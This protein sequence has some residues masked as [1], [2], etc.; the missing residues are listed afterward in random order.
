MC[1]RSSHCVLRSSG[2]RVGLTN[3]PSYLAGR[4]EMKK[5]KKNTVRWLYLKLPQRGYAGASA[6]GPR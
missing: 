2:R 1:D 5:V 3:Q 4:M 6:L